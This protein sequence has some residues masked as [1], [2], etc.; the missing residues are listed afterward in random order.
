MIASF[1]LTGRRALI[2][3]AGSPTGIGFAT[4]ALLGRMG[5]TVHVT[6][7]TDRISDPLRE[8]IGRRWPESRLDVLVNC[9][10][11]T[12]VWVAAGVQAASTFAPRAWRPVA[13]ALAVAAIA[14]VAG[15]RI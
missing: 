15:A 7:T 4:A 2:T 5:A 9:P 13:R 10:W 14:G 3:G 6:A 8:A 11:C 12:G 1:D